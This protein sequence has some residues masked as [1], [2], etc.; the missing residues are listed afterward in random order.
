MKNLHLF[1]KRCVYALSGMILSCL[2]MA[3]C[4]GGS[5][6]INRSAPLGKWGGTQNGQSVSSDPVTMQLT[7]TQVQFQA[8]CQATI[9]INQPLAV[10]SSGH[11]TMSVVAALDPGAQHIPI[12]FS[13]TVVNG[14]MTVT[15]TNTSNNLSIGTYT[16]QYGRQ[17]PSYTGYCGG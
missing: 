11:F 10:D 7:S 2:F 3:G 15:L 17:V 5:S 1:G 12:Q 16:L 6:S 4:G 8:P 13:G 9:S 14:V